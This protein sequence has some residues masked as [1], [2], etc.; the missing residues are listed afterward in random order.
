MSSPPTARHACLSLAAVLWLAF[1]AA[2][3]PQPSGGI[4][5]EWDVRKNLAALAANAQRLQ[6]LLEQLRPQDWISQGA[7]DTYLAQWK[8]TQEQVRGLVYSTEQLTREPEK[9]TAA[10][11]AFFRIE[12][13]GALLRS[14]S[15][16]LRKY[17]NPALADLLLSAAA[18]GAANRERLRQYIVDL[19]ADKEKQFKVMDQEAQR[20]RGLLSR[21][22]PERGGSKKPER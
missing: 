4:A 18:E 19:A 7:P 13:L 15:E 20:C 9:L 3:Q 2:A 14:L 10:L 21:K 16:G 12:A 17:Q 6:P 8:S 1:G 22:P 5:P 11:D